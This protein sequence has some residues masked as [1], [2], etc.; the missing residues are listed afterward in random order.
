M[1]KRGMKEHIRSIHEGKKSYVQCDICGKEF[2]NKSGLKK[3]IATIHE[4]KKNTWLERGRR[5]C[6]RRMEERG[7]VIE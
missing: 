2:T 7:R 1:S 5:V 4:G 3:H 6:Y